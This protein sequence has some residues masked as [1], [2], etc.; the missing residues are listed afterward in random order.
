MFRVMRARNN[1]NG[2]SFHNNETVYTCDFLMDPDIGGTLPLRSVSP[3]S[4]LKNT[5]ENKKGDVV[6]K[7]FAIVGPCK[8]M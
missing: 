8:N 2:T 7:G 3:Q 6:P 5:L 4:P 1:P